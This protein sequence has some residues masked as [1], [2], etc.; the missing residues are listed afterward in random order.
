MNEARPVCAV[1]GVSS[2]ATPLIRLTY[3]EQDAWVCP[4]EMPKLIHDPARIAGT[5][6]GADREGA[7]A[8]EG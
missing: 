5:F 2:E 7:P 8:G 6:P 1:C 3:R 4:Q